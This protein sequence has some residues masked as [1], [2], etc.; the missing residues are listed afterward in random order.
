ML[1]EKPVV[2]M[3]SV[4]YSC[5]ELDRTVNFLQV[6]HAPRLLQCF[7]LQLWVTNGSAGELQGRTM[8]GF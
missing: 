3:G 1:S 5:P 7:S 6:E 4:P 8:N 2:G